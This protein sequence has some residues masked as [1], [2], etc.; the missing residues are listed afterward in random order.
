MWFDQTKPPP[1]MNHAIGP[2][3]FTASAHQFAARAI[4]GKYLA[5]DRF[6]EGHTVPVDR[7][8]AGLF[9]EAKPR[10]NFAAFITVMQNGR[11]PLS[12]AFLELSLIHI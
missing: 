3:Q 7:H 9:F 1:V 6:P 5:L 10:N 2:G 4:R 8:A 11:A 12:H